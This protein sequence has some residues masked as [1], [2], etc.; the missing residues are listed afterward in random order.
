MKLVVVENL[1]NKG[2]RKRLR[3]LG[4]E[5]SRRAVMRA[6]AAALREST[7]FAFEKQS[8]P[9]T[10]EHWLPWSDEWRKWRQQHGYRSDKI[11]EMTGQLAASMTTDYSDSYAVIGSDKVYADIHQW[12]GLPTMPPGPRNIPARPYMGL[13]EEGEDEVYNAISREMNKALEGK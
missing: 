6:T 13:D 7:E 5:D 9:E 8:D 2:I 4:S 11:L 12:G 10:G 3:K 1:A